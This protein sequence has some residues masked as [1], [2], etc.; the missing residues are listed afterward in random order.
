MDPKFVKIHPASETF[1]I[2]KRSFFEND[3]TLPGNAIVGAGSSFWGNLVVKGTLDLG[4][5]SNV[6]G[7]ITAATAVISADSN[8]GGNIKVSG[9]LT[10]LDRVNVGGLAYA[11]GDI[12]IRPMVS[13]R[14]AE[15]TGDILVTGMTNIKSIRSGHKLV[16]R[17]G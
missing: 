7:N 13:A 11:Y 10:L 16:A 1:I 8:I 9:N 12:F 15:C 6:K 3:V 4:W 17:K 14:A 5:G 2:K